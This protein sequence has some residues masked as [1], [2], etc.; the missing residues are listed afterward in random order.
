MI[1]QMHANAAKTM[2]KT[3]TKIKTMTMT[4]T[5]APPP[6]AGLMILTSFLIAFMGNGAQ[7]IASRFY[8]NHSFSDILTGIIIFFLIGCEFFVSYKLE[9]NKHREEA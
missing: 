3:K 2:T 9:H 1:L 4:K 6:N 7:E 5:T 8:L